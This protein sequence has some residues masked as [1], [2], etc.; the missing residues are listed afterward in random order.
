MPTPSPQPGPHRHATYD[1][2]CESDRDMDEV[3][4]TSHSYI[5]RMH[6]HMQWGILSSADTHIYHDTMTY[7][8]APA[9]AMRPPP[10]AAP[11]ATPTSN[12]HT[13]IHAC[14]CKYMC[15]CTYMLQVE[16]RGLGG[17]GHRGWQRSLITWH[18]EGRS[19]PHNI[20]K[21]AHPLSK[22]S[23]ICTRRLLQNLPLLHLLSHRPDGGS[24]RPDAYIHSHI[25]TPCRR[26]FLHRPRPQTHPVTR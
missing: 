4:F 11:P 18:A 5:H 6:K 2:I 9:S 24:R 20:H 19:P 10:P 25:Y 1:S 21:H 3:P 16:G 22:C 26:S 14:A 12:T 17:E 13:R 23:R 8:Q 15:I 7:T